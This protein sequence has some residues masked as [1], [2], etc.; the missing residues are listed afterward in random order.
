MQSEKM[1]MRIIKR[2]KKKEEQ[3][4][5]GGANLYLDRKTTVKDYLLWSQIFYGDAIAEIAPF[6]V[7]VISQAEI[8][9]GKVRGRPESVDR[10]V[11][12][13]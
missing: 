12:R 11:A 1:K 8:G 4:E 13:R 6:F 10:A 3:M 9:G 7:A 5:K 2:G